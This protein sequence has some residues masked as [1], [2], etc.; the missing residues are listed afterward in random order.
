MS[1]A[2]WSRRYLWVCTMLV[3][4][5]LLATPLLVLATPLNPSHL[6]WG[7]LR[8]VLRYYNKESME[9]RRTVH[10][11]YAYVPY[12]IAIQWNISITPHTHPSS[13][14]SRWC[15]HTC[16]LLAMKCS[17]FGVI[18]MCCQRTRALSHSRYHGYQPTLTQTLYNTTTFIPLL[19]L[20]I[21]TSRHGDQS[22]YIGDVRTPP[23]IDWL[24]CTYWEWTH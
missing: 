12:L 10:Q 2:V 18:V 4:H 8:S 23:R 6:Y 3:D 15:L 9:H 5:L 21:A 19:L 11:M 16:S 22:I 13:L 24:M 7:R 20:T 17:I 1:R 14:L